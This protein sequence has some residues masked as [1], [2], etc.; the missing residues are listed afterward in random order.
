MMFR[1]ELEREA[2][3]KYIQ[4]GFNEGFPSAYVSLDASR[5]WLVYWALHSFDLLGFELNQDEFERTLETLRGFQVPETGGF[6]GG[7]CEVLTAHLAPT[8]A[9]VCS[10]AVLAD[11]RAYSLIDRAGLKRFLQSLKTPE[12]SFRM[13]LPDGE[14]DVRAAYCAVVVGKLTGC[15]DSELERG[16]VDWIRSCQ[17]WEGGFGGVPGAEAHGGYTYCALAA[18]KLL[19]SSD[20][21]KRSLEYWLTSQQVEP[22]GGFRGRT[23]KLVDGCYSFW[24]TACFELIGRGKLVDSLALQRFILAACQS[25]DGNGGLRDKPGK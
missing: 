7:D 23:N 19:L 6:C 12:G 1:I 3:I 9:A 11:P 4:K 2:H 16:L 13:H 17:T 18:L 25:G 22:I 15:W 20:V 8:F 14:V 24:Q 21:N 5:P 10:V